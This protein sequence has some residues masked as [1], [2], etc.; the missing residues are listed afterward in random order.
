[1]IKI[2][3]LLS[4]LLFTTTVCTSAQIKP[5]IYR[6]DY[7]YKGEDK[8]NVMDY[9]IEVFN[10]NGYSK[11]MSLSETGECIVYESESNWKQNDTSLI[12]SNTKEK[13]KEK[14]DD[15][16][17]ISSLKESDTYEI[18]VIKDNYFIGYG[19]DD[20]EVFSR[21]VLLTTNQLDNNTSFPE[22][23]KYAK[24]Q[25]E[26]RLKDANKKSSLELL[27]TSGKWYI[28]YIESKNKKRTITGED[29]NWFIFRP[30]GKYE[31]KT[32]NDI[33]NNKWI[34][35]EKRKSISIRERGKFQEFKIEKIHENKII[36]STDMGREGI[37]SISLI[38]PNSDRPR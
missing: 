14:C 13:S 38:K 8:W 37:I 16:F 15:E 17:K 11:Y 21:W 23:M 20:T 22:L 10:E 32:Y 4:I 12:I 9:N 29:N 34:F 6:L 31:M 25:K 19:T 26:L 24:Q 27:I 30:N 28:E 3:N 18:I 33:R 1:M 36:L 7:K 35:N 5:G 2:S